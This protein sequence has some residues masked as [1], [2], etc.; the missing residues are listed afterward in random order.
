MLLVTTV[1][2]GTDIEYFQYNRKFYWPADIKY[3]QYDRKS[4]WPA[5]VHY[6]LLP[7]MCQEPI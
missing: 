6:L 1:L 5:V 3:F 7:T 4:Y 2:D